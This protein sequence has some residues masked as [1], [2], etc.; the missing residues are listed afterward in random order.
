MLIGCKQVISVDPLL[1]PVK[2]V[3]K[4]DLLATS[5]S[6]SILSKYNTCHLPSNVS[7]LHRLSLPPMWAGV[8]SKLLKYYK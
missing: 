8:S 5:P 3:T 7:F 4:R 2:R 1:L 6:N